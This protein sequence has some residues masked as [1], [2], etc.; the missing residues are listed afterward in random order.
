MIKSLSKSLIKLFTVLFFASIGWA[1]YILYQLPEKLMNASKSIDLIQIKLLQPLFN[2]VYLA[3][4]SSFTFGILSIVLLIIFR[5]DQNLKTGSQWKSYSSEK[6]K[7]GSMDLASDTEEDTFP[8]TGL[9]EVMK[10]NAVSDSEEDTHEQQIHIAA[11]EEVLKM[12][13]DK[14]VIF[15]RALSV[16]CKQFEASQAAAY[17]VKKDGE[18]RV[19][20]LFASFAHIIPEGKQVVYRFGEGLAGQAAKEGKLLNIKSVPE[21]YLQ[22]ISGLG[23]ASPTHLIIIPIL[24]NEEVIGVVEIA[25]FKEFSVAQEKALQEC[26]NKLALKLTNIDNVSLE[27]AKR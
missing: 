2:Q 3:F 16:V 6:V 23:K 24:S 19:I 13:D 18:Y 21:G 26:F 20:E 7:K 12:N 17:E 15:N 25:S 9:G 11:I 8:Q 22:I 4:G 14:H 27:N 10:M 1:A 5:R